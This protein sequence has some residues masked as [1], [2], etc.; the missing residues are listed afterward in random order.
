MAVLVLLPKKR[1]S[2]YRLRRIVLTKNMCERKRFVHL[3]GYRKTFPKKTAL[4][5]EHKNLVN[6]F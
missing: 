5:V 1:Q 2:E 4:N 3:H 6:V